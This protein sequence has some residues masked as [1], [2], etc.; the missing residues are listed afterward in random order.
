M[1]KRAK[2]AIAAGGATVL[3]LGGLGSLAYWSDSEV[4][5][6]ENIASGELSLTSPTDAA[7]FDMTGELEEPIA[8]IAD[9][10]I[11]PGD[12][13][14]YRASVEVNASGDN[15]EAELTADGAGVTTGTDLADR[16]LV[17]FSAAVGVVPLPVT[18]GDVYTVTSADDG[19]TI[20]VVVTITF[21]SET[22]LEEAQNE[23]VSLE[24][25]TIDL[26]QVQQA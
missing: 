8:T 17:D 3:L 13:I 18:D 5:G 23:S 2:G 24:N 19:D 1:N 21:D 7:W 10:E 14:E 20:D 6:G 15:L 26:Q 9:F 4:T 12:V 11:V 22:P 16:L 25:F